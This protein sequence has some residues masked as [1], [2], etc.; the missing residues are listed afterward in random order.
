M[1]AK[2]NTHS[3]YCIQTDRQPRQPNTTDKEKHR[4]VQWIKYVEELYHQQIDLEM[5][6]PT[7]WHLTVAPGNGGMVQTTEENIMETWKETRALTRSTGSFCRDKWFVS[8]K[9]KKILLMSGWPYKHLCLT[10]GS[11]SSSSKTYLHQPPSTTFC[12]VIVLFGFV[13]LFLSFF[14]CS[15]FVFVVLVVSIFSIFT[16]LVNCIK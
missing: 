16:Y 11:K 1:D 8:H 10:W 4:Q 7:D 14:F 15:F 13:C 9:M 6:R 3:V 2:T 12:L 5:D